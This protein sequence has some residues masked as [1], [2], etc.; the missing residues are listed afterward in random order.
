MGLSNELQDQHYVV[1]DGT[2]G[3]LH[4]AEVGRLSRFD[5]PARDI[6]VSL[7][8]GVLQDRAQQSPKRQSRLFIESHVQFR[9]LATAEGATW[10]DRKLL[11]RQPETF[12]E[13]GFGAE[14]NRALRQ[15]QRWLIQE[16]LM[17]EQNGHLNARRRM[18]DE[19]TRQEVSKA[20]AA[21]SKATGMEH[22]AASEL[23][24]S[25]VQVNRS[26]RLASGR[27]AVLQ[28]GKQFAIVPWQQAMR[29]RKGMGIGAEAGKGLSR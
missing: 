7:R 19:L 13:N 17:T 10:L 27:F 16:G 21:M 29:M 14:A 4:Y 2:D 9:D 28:K 22:V 15:R 1:V 20:G 5:P 23:G 6:V 3:K 24:R 26:V 11:S 8:G 12:R 25:G 18:L